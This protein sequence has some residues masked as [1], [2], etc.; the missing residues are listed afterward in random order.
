MFGQAGCQ[1]LT[2]LPAPPRP[3][4]PVSEAV[5]HPH[6]LSEG[7]EVSGPPGAEQKEGTP[8]KHAPSHHR[9]AASVAEKDL[10]GRWGSRGASGRGK[11]VRECEV[12]SA[13]RSQESGES[14]GL[15]FL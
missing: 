10:G 1:P 3:C 12:S 5:N 4:I 11:G 2:C 14:K 7:D 9:R 13:Q 6:A 8:H 15:Y